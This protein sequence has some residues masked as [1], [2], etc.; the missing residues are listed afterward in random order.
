MRKLLAVLL[1][2][3]PLLLAGCGGGDDAAKKAR[4]PEPRGKYVSVTNVQKQAD[5]LMVSATAVAEAGREADL[6]FGAPGT[7]VQ[8][9]AG[10]GM[11]VSQG[12][13][14]A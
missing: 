10:K 11:A 4:E 7:I 3:L 13:V 6:S 14:L 1:T 5:S 12:Q 9:L 2:L 8:V